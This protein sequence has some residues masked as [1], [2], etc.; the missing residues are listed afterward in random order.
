MATPARAHL[1][2]RNK[3]R[4]PRER[5]TPTRASGP[6]GREGTGTGLP[7]RT[8]GAGVQP[9]NQLAA[10]GENEAALPHTQKLHGWRRRE[11]P[12]GTPR[13]APPPREQER[14]SARRPFS[15][16]AGLSC[17]SRVGARRYLRVG[18]VPRPAARSETPLAA[19]SL[20]YP[21]PVGSC[22]H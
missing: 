19:A 9:Q 15:Q 22:G 7:P 5:V 11:E 4:A 3:L 20:L 6:P 2:A 8:R 12:S 14:I 16:S 18:M 13:R 1:P 10:E 21:A 17:G